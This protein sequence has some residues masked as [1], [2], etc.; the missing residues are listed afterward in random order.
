M[1]EIKMFSYV[2]QLEVVYSEDEDKI[3]Q[4]LRDVFP[5]PYKVQQWY[6]QRYLMMKENK[7]VAVIL[8]LR[9]GITYRRIQK[10]IQVAPNTIVEIRANYSDMNI[11]EYKGH[12]D[13]K[14]MV[15]NFLDKL[16]RRGFTY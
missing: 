9:A 10:I 7:P 2:R 12:E 16:E 6:H 14:P 11:P 15:D 13:M 1:S 3:V 4:H 5:N 8:A